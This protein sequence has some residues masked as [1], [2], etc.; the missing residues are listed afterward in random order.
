MSISDTSLPGGDALR[1][2]ISYSRKDTDVADGLLDAL[3]ARG[4]SIKIDRRDLP[5]GEKWQEQLTGFIAASD[6][7]IFLLSPDSIQSKWC[8]WEL[9]EVSRLSKRLFVIRIR[10]TDT[11][12]L[13]AEIKAVQILPQVGL[14]AQREHENT[15]V[16]ALNTDSAW[17]RKGSTLADDAREWLAHDQDSAMLLRGRALTEA[18]K[19]VK[20]RPPMAPKPHADIVALIS[21]SRNRRKTVIRRL[22]YGTAA[23]LAAVAIAYAGYRYDQWYRLER[24]ETAYC[25]NYAEEWALPVCVGELTTGELRGRALYYEIDRQAGRV[26]AMRR[27]NGSGSLVDASGSYQATAFE[28]EIW[29]RGVARWAYPLPRGQKQDVIHFSRGGVQLRTMQLTFEQTA[30]KVRH[31]WAEYALKGGDIERPATEGTSLGDLDPDTTRR[32]SIGRH[33]LTFDQGRLVRRMFEVPGGGGAARDVNG[34]FG[35]IYEHYPSGLV[36]TIKSVNSAGN[37]MADRTGIQSQVRHYDAGG[38]LEKIEFY[39]G[40]D[41]L[42]ASDANI[43]GIDFIRDPDGKLLLTNYLDTDRLPTIHRTEGVASIAYDYEGTADIR[44]TRFL[45]KAQLPAIYLPWGVEVARWEYNELGDRTAVAYFEGSGAKAMRSDLGVHGIKWGYDAR[46]RIDET[47]YFGLDGA[48]SARVDWN[49]SRE[50]WI[51]TELGA[52]KVVAFFG[53]D[54]ETALRKDWNAA[55]AVWSVD[56]KRGLTTG[57]KFLDRQGRRTLRKA[58]QFARGKW[59]YDAQ[60]NEEWVLYFDVDDKPIPLANRGAAVIKYTHDSAGQKTDEEYFDGGDPLLRVASANATTTL[61]TANRKPEEEVAGNR[62]G[63]ER[64]GGGQPPLP[65]TG[66]D[67]GAYHLK[68]SYGTRGDSTS[69]LDRLG[70]LMPKKGGGHARVWREYN[71]RGDLVLERYED[72]ARKPT[73]N[74]ELGAHIVMREYD[75][76]RRETRREFRGIQKEFVPAKDWGVAIVI[77]AY[78]D[79][80]NLVVESYEDTGGQATTR[81]DT[82]VARVV[83]TRDRFGRETRRAYFDISGKPAPTLDWGVAGVDTAYDVTGNP[84]SERYFD[85]SGN[86]V[87]R[88]DNSVAGIDWA[89]GPFGR[90]IERYVGV[91]GK[92][93]LDRRRVS[94]VR[95]EYD[96]LGNLT[97][98]SFLDR[99]DN[100]TENVR[101][102]AAAIVYGRDRFGRIASERHLDAGGS[103]IAHESHAA[104]TRWFYDPRG[105]TTEKRFVDEHGKPV[106]PE[107]EGVAAWLWSYDELDRWTEQRYLDVSGEPTSRG[108]TDPDLSSALLTTEYDPYGNRSMQRYFDLEDKETLDGGVGYAAIRRRFDEMNRLVSYEF[109]DPAGNPMNGGIAAVE[110]ARADFDYNALGRV[111]AVRLYGLAELDGGKTELRHGMTLTRSHDPLGRLASLSVATTDGSTPQEYGMVPEVRYTYDE[112]HRINGISF[113]DVGGSPLPYLEDVVR[114]TYICDP[115]GNVVDER[116]FGPDGPISATGKPARIAREFEDDDL[117]AVF[118]YDHAGN[119]VS[120]ENLEEWYFSLDYSFPDEPRRAPCA[121]AGW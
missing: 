71:E 109:L 67:T 116:F 49:V 22:A 108:G 24:I 10:D 86:P 97:R 87:T 1:I 29:D 88:T 50:K 72:A 9:E 119:P 27:L 69:Y 12:E 26:V 6:T 61:A 115:R 20:S 98:E 103:L 47:E 65:V 81:A 14:Y 34:A 39:D 52:P 96:D 73:L 104:E 51:F 53:V 82:G 54:G 100:P 75:G 42:S 40:E 3:K 94:E 107:P 13:P 5:Y 70:D 93:T 2:F 68:T 36:R 117:V 63:E 46:R 84:V 48:P 95:R 55:F 38:E 111:K 11:F 15:L 43:A 59:V 120:A 44:Q 90:T 60:G 89:Y 92:P 33:I 35:R 21:T 114:V 112:R 83:K 113:H 76:S 62:M 57:A 118:A 32:S 37:P 56:P 64:F 101:N 17:L 105:N 78:D 110:R 77:T 121:R 91:D 85:V 23:G 102:G 28:T 18:E 74:R 8:R 66:S 80:R 19:W 16:S 99:A 25:R 31:A 106:A 4:F 30:G 7:I 45:D 79:N 58:G 41:K